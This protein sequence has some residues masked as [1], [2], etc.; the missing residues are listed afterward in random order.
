M[1]VNI[2]EN[3]DKTSRFIFT[4]KISKRMS[5]VIRIPHYTVLDKSRQFVT[6]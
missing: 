3:D 4:H 2:V 5:C 1:T 6:I